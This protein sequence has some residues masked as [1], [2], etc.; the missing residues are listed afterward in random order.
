MTEKIR[1]Q[2]FLSQKGVF[3]RR[4]TE[5]LI[6]EKRLKINGKIVKL[7]DRVLNND[8]ISIDNQP[9][10]IKKTIKR[11]VIAFYKPKGVES[12]LKPMLDIKT[13]ADFD[14][15]ARVF[16][17]GRLDKDSHGLLLLT[18]DGDLSNHL[19]HPRYQKEKEYLVVVDKDITKSFISNLEKGVVIE[20]SKTKECKVEYIEPRIFKIILTEGKNRQIRK[21]CLTQGY[22]VKDL[23]RIRFGPCNLGELGEG[24]FRV[25]TEKEIKSL[26]SN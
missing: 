6:R 4:E 15:G 18:N 25:M 7:G 26:T 19:A 20:E 17:I 23:L 8:I 10:N 9:I 3:S 5:K 16:P 1:I 22:T 13:L 14:F 11:K 12:T 2:K 24:R 21:M